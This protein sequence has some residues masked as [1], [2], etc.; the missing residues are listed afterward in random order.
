MPTSNR[1]RAHILIVDDELSL[2][3]FLDIYLRR[4]GFTCESASSGADA[5]RMLS[6]KEQRFDVV[7]TDL[8]MPGINGMEVLRHACALPQPPVVIMMTAF[9]STET[10]ITAM[11]LGAYDY[12]TKPFKID[13]VEVVLTRAIESRALRAENVLLKEKLKGAHHLES[14]VGRS[15]SMQKVFDL[16]RRVADTKSNVLIRGESGTGKEL[17]ARALHNLSD[18]AEKPFIAINCGAIPDSLMESELFG[19]VKGSFTGAKSDRKGIFQAAEDGT[20]FLDEV[21]E[22][23]PQIQVKL[24]RVLQERRVRPIGSNQEIACSARVIAA[25]NRDLEAAISSGEFRQDL[26]FRLNVI[27]IVLPPLRHRS[28]DIPLL[29]ERFFQRYNVEMKR[30]LTGI[31]PAAIDLF[32]AYD[33]PG[34]VRELENLVERAV[35]LESGTQLT[36]DHLSELQKATRQQSHDSFPEQGL[37]LDATV[38]DLERRLILTAL[39]RTHGVRKDAAE[40]LQISFRS[41]RYRLQKLGIEIGQVRDPDK[42]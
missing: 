22:V 8:T 5:L 18:R 3:D 19:H 31:S 2:R 4:S 1:R 27:Q 39:K 24:L 11:K 13:E 20:I 41:L 36:S 33:Y 23:N 9:A 28:E 16:V 37:D 21:G 12:L 30:E 10:A 32:L 29:V 7:L 38:S 15:E 14:M 40:L 34:N 26:Y 42:T 6:A 25:T 35:A 17:V